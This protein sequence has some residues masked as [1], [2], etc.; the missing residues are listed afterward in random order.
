MRWLKQTQQTYPKIKKPSGDKIISTYINDKK[1]KNNYTTTKYKRQTWINMGME[2]Y[3]KDTKRQ[4]GRGAF[5][6]EN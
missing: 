5:G 3:D 4:V 6:Y 1:E 2:K